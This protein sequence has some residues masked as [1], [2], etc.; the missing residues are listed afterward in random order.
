MLDDGIRALAY[1]HNVTIFKEI[2]KDCDKKDS[3]KEDRKRLWWL[4]KVVIIEK[5]Y[6]DWKRL[7]LKKSCL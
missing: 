4:K 2:E 7:S 3:D 6:D 1:F 5:D